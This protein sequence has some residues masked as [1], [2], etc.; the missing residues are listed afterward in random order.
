[1]VMLDASP[2]SPPRC[3]SVNGM[4]LSPTGSLLLEKFESVQAHNKEI[5][6][7]NEKLREQIDQVSF[8]RQNSSSPAGHNQ[9]RKCSRLYGV[10]LPD[11]FTEGMDFESFSERL[12]DMGVKSS[13]VNARQA[14]KDLY[15]RVQQHEVEISKRGHR[16]LQQYSLVRV[17]LLAKIAGAERCLML[18][19]QFD[20]KNGNHKARCI[21][22][23]IRMRQKEDWQM[24]ARRGLQTMVGL[25]PEWQDIHI[26]FDVSSHTCC[27]ENTSPDDNPLDL[28]V[29]VTVHEVH[30]RL[31]ANHQHESNG[32]AKEV[33]HDAYEQIGLP[34]GRD[35]V[36]CE[37]SRSTVHVWCWKGREHEQN[38]RIKSFE[39][40]LI[41]H[42]VDTAKF[43]VDNNMT[44]FKFYQQI[45]EQKHCTLS[46]VSGEGGGV[47]LMCIVQQLK[48]KLVAE[49][50]KRQRVLMENEQADPSG[51]KR[52]TGQF[53]TRNLCE[54]EDWLDA[55]AVAIEEL[56]GVSADLQAECFKVDQS[57]TTYTE[58]SDPTSG[59][60]GIM[61][62]FQIRTV[63]VYVVEPDNEALQC[64][65]LPRG[66]DFVS[67]E[68]GSLGG[69]PDLHVW[70]WTPFAEADNAGTFAGTA[71]EVLNRDLVDVGNILAQTMADTRLASIGLSQAFHSSVNKIKMCAERL[72][73]IDATVGTIDVGAVMNKPETSTAMSGLKSFIE[74]NFVRS[75]KTEEKKGATWS[76]LGKNKCGDFGSHA[77]LNAFTFEG[78][79]DAAPDLQKT[80][81]NARDNWE[82]N[83]FELVTTFENDA[84]AMLEAYGNVMVVPFCVHSFMS[85]ELSAQGFIRA[86]SGLYHDNP[87]HGPVH[88]AQVTHLAR[89]LTKAMRVMS[90][91]TE[92]ESTAFM[93]AAFCH[94]IK[95]I[96]R[97]NNFCVVSEHP[98]ALLYNNSSVLENYHSSS[99]LELLQEFRVLEHLEM[100]DRSSVRSHIIDSILA[101]DMQSHFETISKFRVRRDAADF[102]VEVEADRKFLAKLCL[103]AGDLGHACLPWD[104]HVEWATRVTQEFY[105]QGDEERRLGIGVSP[106]CDRSDLDNIG[107]S[108]KGFLDFVVAP[109]YQVLSECQLKLEASMQRLMEDS[110]CITESAAATN[111]ELKPHNKPANHRASTPDHLVLP[112]QDS[113]IALLQQNSERWMTDQDVI[114]QV[115]ESL[116][117]DQGANSDAGS[118][119]DA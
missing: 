91:Q 47:E 35:F 3:L 80:I 8:N 112:V 28:L 84:N 15:E 69:G 30:A 113:C 70:T 73:N 20:L 56:I 22:L 44:L 58:E 101:T 76:G 39:Q 60:A 110:P 117:K 4:R 53:I 116:A 57:K 109:L 11:I 19:D 54:G 50:N 68:F 81:A 111:S 86:A 88:A 49:V 2:P 92:L 55:I 23:E 77:D 48:I 7:E 37:P 41:D 95:H 90:A 34:S 66:N 102:S 74:S 71:L 40:Y 32:E 119:F 13:H 67:K 16:L 89:W 82:F 43:G 114:G 78:V 96:G 33:E 107:K 75:A 93:V 103:K 65:G 105:A 72:T 94:D 17:Y 99:C 61:S 42:G 97:N 104:T 45:K 5:L 115:K 18:H 9:P 21:P 52:P 6:A 64:I 85:T 63:T 38:A 26:N 24:A 62:K 83:Y 31:K 12:L 10:A 106:L 79:I 27:T 100:E 1:M 87:Y 14:L 25:L 51:R 118:V 36:Y 98:L 46:E 29:S 59:T 108:Q